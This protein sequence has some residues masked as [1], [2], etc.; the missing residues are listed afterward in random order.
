VFGLVHPR[1]NV[2]PKAVYVLATM[3]GR[4][5]DWDSPV[6]TLTCY[7]IVAALEI[8]VD[9]MDLKVKVASKIEK[10]EL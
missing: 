3:I 9:R 10:F 5:R 6:L 8:T 7:E 1:E 4:A 2:M